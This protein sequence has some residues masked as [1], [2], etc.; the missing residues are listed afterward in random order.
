MVVFTSFWSW[1]L[2]VSWIFTNLKLT[3]RLSRVNIA[4]RTCWRFLGFLVLILT[5]CFWNMSVYVFIHYSVFCGR[6]FFIFHDSVWLVKSSWCAHFVYFLIS[7]RVAIVTERKLCWGVFFWK[8]YRD[9]AAI[10]SFLLGVDY[11]TFLASTNLKNRCAFLRLVIICWLVNGTWECLINEFGFF[12]RNVSSYG[13]ISDAVFLVTIF[14]IFR[15]V[16][17]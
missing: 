2:N 9:N 13:F 12:S 7:L 1:L 17:N 4:L 8:N 3:A 16:S 14:P 15:T 5:L 11:Q 10:F 6:I